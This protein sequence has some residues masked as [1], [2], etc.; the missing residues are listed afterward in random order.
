MIPW[1]MPSV[2]VRCTRMDT[3]GARR[4]PRTRAHARA[5]ARTRMRDAGMC[6]RDAGMCERLG[7]AR[8]WP[9]AQTHALR[10]AGRHVGAR[11]LWP[12]AG[13]ARKQRS[14]SERMQCF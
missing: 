10:H 1:L 4:G 11:R 6:E 7:R 5:R 2:G 9:H 12:A 13:N 8:R 3:L 14:A